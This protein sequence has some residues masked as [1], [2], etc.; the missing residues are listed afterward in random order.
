[1]GWDEDRSFLF[2]S[3]LLFSFPQVSVDVVSEAGEVELR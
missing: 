3:F 1:M 2:F